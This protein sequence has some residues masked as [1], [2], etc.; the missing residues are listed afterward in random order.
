M[1]R[2]FFTN[3]PINRDNINVGV[4]KE[5]NCSG[6][7]GKLCDRAWWQPT[8][9]IWDHWILQNNQGGSVHVVWAEESLS[10]FN[11]FHMLFQLH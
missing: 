6:G 3:C 10:N 1:E 5:D 4:A 8:R 2:K 11:G 9:M 7:R